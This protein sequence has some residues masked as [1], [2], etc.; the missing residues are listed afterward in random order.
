MRSPFNID[1]DMVVK[2]TRRRPEAHSSAFSE[3]QKLHS[4][5]SGVAFV[6]N[7]SPK[8][9][10]AIHLA[11]LRAWGQLMVRICEESRLHLVLT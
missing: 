4:A 10:I 7:R 9:K 8:Q 6:G 5:R 2:N 1:G 3:L 11:Q